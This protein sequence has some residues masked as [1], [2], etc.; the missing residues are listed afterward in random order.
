MATMKLTNRQQVKI[1]FVGAPSLAQV[2][3]DSLRTVS[4]P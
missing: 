2:A 3:E 1:L 4:V